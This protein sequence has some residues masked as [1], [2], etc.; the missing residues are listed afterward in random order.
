[1]MDTA[2]WRLWILGA[3]G[4][5]S[6]GNGGGE[7]EEVG[8]VDEEPTKSNGV[9][10]KRDRSTE[11]L[12]EEDRTVEDVRE[13]HRPSF[14]DRGN[15]FKPPRSPPFEACELCEVEPTEVE[16]LAISSA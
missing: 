16:P 4:V 14:H 2:I 12:K 3:M 5:D 15:I 8:N 9:R 1:M 6:P 13:S 11:W 7:E 10:R